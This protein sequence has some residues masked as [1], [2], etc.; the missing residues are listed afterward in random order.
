MLVKEILGWMNIE[1]CIA[2]TL[3]VNVGESGKM[4]DTEKTRDQLLQELQELRH[5][6]G[7]V[8][9]DLAARKQSEAAL[10]YAQSSIDRVPEAIHWVGTQGNFLYVNDAA[11]RSLGYTREELLFMTVFDI[12][13]LFTWEIWADHWQ[14]TRDLGSHTIETQHQ[15]KAGRIFPVEI[16]INF[17]S[18]AEKEFFCA[19][20]RDITERQQ[21]EEALRFSESFLNNIIDQ[22]PYPICISDHQGT[23][24]KLNQACQDLFQ[25]TVDEAVGKYNLFQDNILEEQGFL[26]LVKR[27]FELGETAQFEIKYDSSQL[28]HLQLINFNSVILESTIFPIKDANGRITNVVVQHLDIT[29]RKQAE[30]ENARLVAQL[31][32]A[33]KMEAVGRLA[34]GVAHDFNNML[35][36][37][38]GYADLIKNRLSLDDPI[39]EDISEIL[40][41][42]NHSRDI[43]R[44]LLAFSRQQ[45]IAPRPM[46]LNDLITTTQKTLGLLIGEDIDLHFYPGE[47]LGKIM[48]DPTQMEQI[49][50]NLAVNARD[51]M[52]D[53]GKLTVETT[54]IYLD[55]AYCQE[56]LGF[57]SGHY[58]MLGV[59]DDGVGMDRETQ[60]HVFEPFFTTKELG[61]G[62]GLGLATVYGIVKQNQGFINI[63]SELGRGTTFKV[64]VP[65][66]LSEDQL[67]EESETTPEA[68]GGGTV[69]LVEDDQMVRKTSRAMLEAIGYTVIVAETPMDALSWC[70]QKERRIDLLLTDVVMPEMNGP[71]LRNRIIAL[72]PEI[73]VLFMS[74]YTADVIAHR[75]VLNKGVNFIEK[76]FRIKDLAR[77]VRQVI[78]ER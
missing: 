52:P 37:I 5:R 8:E 60:T 64:Y 54:N 1:L 66:S 74:G 70:A 36:V 59:S 63:Y 65:R 29:A 61:K 71:E 34:G 16:V 73:K 47:D 76:P 32:M 3:N 58:V 67:T 53:G 45:I 46:N 26:P 28:K 41:A 17:I 31:L 39:L 42:A 33:Q 24:I 78:A 9:T 77:K 18:F 20:V 30:E 12:D 62:T 21:T 10:R 43:I 2:S 35:S 56:H 27:V 6:L 55:E 13:P 40:Q 50:V 23:F 68:P 25:I 14:T 51:A 19:Y 7:A 49:I 11:C 15:T 38:L 75:G 72:R 44:Q 57:K 69:L 4:A 48:F 22:S